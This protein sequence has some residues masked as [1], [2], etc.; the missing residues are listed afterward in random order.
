MFPCEMRKFEAPAEKL[1]LA[2]INVDR[3]YKNVNRA[4]LR[5]HWNVPD[6]T[7]ELARSTFWGQWQGRTPEAFIWLRI[8]AQKNE[9]DSGADLEITFT[10]TDYVQSLHTREIFRINTLKLELISIQV[11]IDQ[12]E[13]RI[14]LF[15]VNM[16]ESSVNILI[17]ATTDCRLH[18]TLNCWP[19]PAEGTKW[20]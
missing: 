6:C 12:L 5:T 2:L 17:P 16:L 19:P 8:S 3:R 1:P 11:P 20:D 15:T 10:I 13:S 4:R 9:S 18:I 7:T 14:R